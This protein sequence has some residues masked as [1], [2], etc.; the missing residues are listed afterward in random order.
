MRNVSY[1][2]K[3]NFNIL[4]VRILYHVGIRQHDHVDKLAKE[5]FCKD[6][7]NIYLGMSFAKVAHI[8]KSSLKEERKSDELA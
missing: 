2:R 6:T 3:R 1:A 7:V 8:L 4:F 5:A